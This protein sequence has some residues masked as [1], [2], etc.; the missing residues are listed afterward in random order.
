MFSLDWILQECFRITPT[1]NP[2]EREHI[3]TPV[4]LTHANPPHAIPTQKTCVGTSPRSK[5]LFEALYVSLSHPH[6]YFFP[7]IWKTTTLEVFPTKTLNI[8][9]Y[10]CIP[11]RFIY[12]FNPYASCYNATIPTVFGKSGNRKSGKWPDF[13]KQSPRK[14][15]LLARPKRA[16][17]GGKFAFRIDFIPI[18]V[19]RSKWLTYLPPLPLSHTF[20][21]CDLT[22]VATSQRHPNI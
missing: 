9:M 7:S 12:P 22:I 16:A 4:S 20:L 15:R 21:V 10:L 2:W 3:Y 19:T 8:L 1:S 18:S 5:T 17:P 6:T 11:T 14:I 13:P